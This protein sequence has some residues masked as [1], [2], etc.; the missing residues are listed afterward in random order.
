MLENKYLEG[1]VEILL[2]AFMLYLF[3]F[4]FDIFFQRRQQRFCILC[5]ILA[6]IIWLLGIPHIIYILPLG[7]KISIAYLVLLFGVTTIF[8]GEFWKK[9]FFLITFVAIWMM[10]ETL[11]GNLLMIY[12]EPLAGSLVFGSFVSK[13]LFFF[14]LAAMKKVFTNEEV[15]AIPVYHNILLMLIPIGSIYVMDT[16]FMLG[17]QVGQKYA[18]V[19]SLISSV[20]LLLINVLV[21]YIYIKLAEDLQIRQANLVYEQQLEL[22]ERHQEETEIA[23]LKIRE[24]RHNMRNNFISILAYSEKGE[25]EKIVG[26]INDIMEQG[27]LTLSSVVNTGNIVTDSLIGYWHKVAENEEIE[28]R[29]ELSIPIEMP[30]KG[31]DISLI[32][33]NLLE[34]ALE[35]ARKA[36]E[37]KYI[38]LKMK[39]DKSNLLIAI[40]NSYKGKI[41]RTKGEELKTTKPDAMNHGIGLSSVRRT[42]RKYQGTMVVDDTQ[43]GCF[44]VRVVLYGDSV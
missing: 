19:S 15:V 7:W 27:D 14:V 6:L 44:I 43:P 35:G 18:E 9:C 3:F 21:F 30:F 17:Y 34:N 2:A 16:V 41:I 25:H 13:I 29:T 24:V 37:K 38:R 10:I 5:G 12:C 8:V 32:L 31:A 42:T 22:C 20:I 23:A 33:G 4:Y 40:E 11:A 1:G 26:F 28:F 36:E 39:Y